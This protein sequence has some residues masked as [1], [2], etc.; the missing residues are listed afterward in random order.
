MNPQENV[1]RIKEM[2]GIISENINFD[3]ITFFLSFQRI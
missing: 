1:H 3:E 2:M